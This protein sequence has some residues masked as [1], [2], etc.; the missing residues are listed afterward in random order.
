MTKLAAFTGAIVLALVVVAAASGGQTSASTDLL[1]PGPLSGQTLYVTFTVV[2][3]TPVVPYEYALENTCTYP[4]KTFGHRTLGQHDAIV[5]W[6]D[7]D[8]DHNPVVTMPVYL[9]SVPTGS[10]CR[11]ALV[12]NNT[13]VKG[14]AVTY[15]VG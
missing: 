2:S 8:A 11:I 4:P 7:E 9:Q 5:T 12:D 1:A 10:A 15:T 3:T 13:V 6:T 14:S